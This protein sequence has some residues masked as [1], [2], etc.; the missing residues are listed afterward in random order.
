MD[1]VDHGKQVLGLILPRNGK[2]G[3]KDLL[4]L[5]LRQLSLEHFADPQQRTVF[6]L[7]ERYLDQAGLVLT[8]GIIGDAFRGQQPGLALQY[9]TYFDALA[10]LPLEGTFEY[11]CLQL[12]ELAAERMTGEALAQSMEI[13]H[14]GAMDGSERIQGHLAARQHALAAFG[15]IDRELNQQDAPEGDMRSEAEDI[16]AEYGRRAEHRRT[17]TGTVA[18]SF[19]ALDHVLGGGLQPGEVCLVAADTNAGKTSLVSQWAWHAVTQQGKNVV[20]FTSETNRVQVRFKIIARHSRWAAD[21]YQDKFPQLRR[22][23]N[24]RDL[25]AGTLNDLELNFFRSVVHNFAGNPLHGRC[26]V[27]Q[28]PRAA[29]ISTVEARLAS[30]SRMFPVDL[31][32]IDSLYLLRGDRKRQSKREELSDI[33]VEANQLATTFAHGHGVPLISPWQMNREGNKEARARGFYTTAD[34]AETAEASN[35]ADLILSL[36]V[37]PEVADWRAAPIRLGTVKVRE[38]ER[39]SEPLDLVVDY[40]TSYFEPLGGT[41]RQEDPLAGMDLGGVAP[42]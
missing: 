15:Q 6:Q 29:T 32:I 7:C 23:L 8:R 18:T 19:A 16:F 30:I 26:Y 39:L 21:Q 4:E 17:G 9:E 42:V 20:I 35:T 1:A 34:L 11:H 38:G 2:D 3:R 12:R 27:A 28:V 41:T 31:V 13:L 24:T 25:R 5:A 36:I 33:V 22:G 40:A 37:A 10:T 14:H